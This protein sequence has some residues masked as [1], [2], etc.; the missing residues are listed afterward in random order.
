M[1]CSKLFFRISLLIFWLLFSEGCQPGTGTI[2]TVEKEGKVYGV[3]QGAFRHKWW[4][5]YERGLSYA[6]GRLWKQAEG[7][8]R[9]A[10]S[11]RAGDQF[12]ARTYGMHFLDYFPLR[13]LGIALFYQNRYAEAIQE[14]EKSLAAQKSAKAEFYLDKARAKRIGERKSDSRPPEISLLTPAEGFLS[15]Q[16]SLT[17]TGIATDDTYVKSIRVNGAPVRVDVSAKE[18]SFA[19]EV[20]LKPGENLIRVEAAD[21]SGKKAETVRRVCCDRAGPILNIDDLSLEPASDRYRIKGYAYDDAG[22]KSIQVN[23]QEILQSPGTEV[24]L[25]HPVPAPHGKAI[26]IAEDRIGNRTRAEYRAGTRISASPDHFLPPVLLA[27]LE[28]T[29]ASLLSSSFPKQRQEEFFS[30]HV[31]IPLPKGEAGFYLAQADAEIS[32]SERYLKRL[33]RK[34]RKQGKDYALLI[35]I[36]D[37]EEWAPLKT[38]VNDATALKALLTGKYG[39]SEENIIL[40]KDT[41]AL[42]RVLI[43]DL[44]QMAAGL[45]EKD[46]LLIYYAG[47]GQLDDLTSD[48][49][50]I[51]ADGGRNDPT[52]WIT[53]STIRNILS[54]EKVRGKNIMVIADSCYSGNLLRGGTSLI[55]GTDTAYQAKVLELAHRKSRQIVT[56]GGV[57]P[58]A[59]AGRDNHSLFAYYLLKALEENPNPVMDMESLIVTEVW[60]SVSEKGG[61]RPDVGRLQTAMDENGQFVLVQGDWSSVSEEEE[62]PGAEPDAQ[63][64]GFQTAHRNQEAA[65]SKRVPAPSEL[66]DTEPPLVNIKGW[67]EKRTV[68]LERVYIEGNAADEGGI[69]SLTV[70]NQKVLKKPGRNVYFNYLADLEEGDNVFLIRCADPVGNVTEKKIEIHRKLPK[71]MEMDSRMSV[72]LFPFARM[73]SADR[74]IKE[75]LLKQLVESRR[76]NMREWKENLTAAVDTQQ[77]EAAYQDSVKKLAGELNTDF[78]LIGNF[79]QKDSSLEISARMVEA[80]SF[81]I[82]THE[83]VYGEDIDREMMATLCEGLVLKLCD[84]L[85]LVQGKIVKIKDGEVILNLGKNQNLKKGMHL[86]FFAR[87][88]VLKDPD[89]GE[90]L[91][92]DVEEIGTARIEKLMEKL[93]CA[94][95]F[96]KDIL[97]K[98][99]EGSDVVTR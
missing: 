50:W 35:G 92:A 16:P 26:V 90:E 49:Y 41:E 5:Y 94:E 58:V 8:F 97:G 70:N 88:E 53:N 99:R 12:R 11:G 87:G 3:T 24:V 66:P 19:S 75:A 81:E 39:Y 18:I 4:N 42:R 48:G 13:E 40:R 79:I 2:G 65:K 1:L 17:I 9:Q 21:L 91:G 28:T 63:K 83:D 20:P 76:F 22:I 27:S 30:G 36:N 51:P 34:Y 10:L 37:Y 78:V 80:E 6:D 45:G 15:N 32:T 25:N 72:A 7:D 54:S 84:S 44:R 31:K 14:L 73:R 93:S 29:D 59:D 60:K 96:E 67:Q 69:Q 47:H 56:S 68:F 85:P 38:A 86:I 89:T 52:T 62:E 77:D 95:P 61:Q 82:L 71:V 57:E 23:G 46:N 74:G 55:T 64:P 98:L 43:Q 33:L